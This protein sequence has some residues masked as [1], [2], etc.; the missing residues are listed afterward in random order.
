MTALRG[1]VPATAISRGGLG[2][3]LPM[4]GTRGIDQFA[5][6]VA[7]LLIARRTG[8][9][10]FAPFATIF[11][12]YAF[13][14]QVGD[15]GLAFAILR[16]R[17]EQPISSRSWTVRMLANGV[18]A[19]MAVAAGLLVGGSVGVVIGFGGLSLLTGPAVYIG[20][21][22]LQRSRHTRRLSMG[23]A[24]GAVAF[25]T[26]VVLLVRDAD[27]LFAFASICIVKHL[28]E[29]AVQQWPAG[30]FDSA[31][32][33][34]RTQGVWVSQLVTYATANVDYLI[35]GALL[36]EVAL[37][38]YAIGFRLASAFSSIVCIATDPV[39]LCRLRQHR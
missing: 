4:I 24:T 12:L 10:A 28:I 3:L 37:S 18:V 38:I 23:E 15:T 26:A 8:T 25:L 39:H 36:G 17:I 30:V 16:T 27:D 29:L 34:V 19:A 22:S 32:I 21:A 13:T 9:Q 33:P 1:L 31:G 7:S 14:A 2:R 6:G 35:V 20:R 11:I 5:L